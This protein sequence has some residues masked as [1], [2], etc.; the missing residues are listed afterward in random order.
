[1]PP[2]AS[3]SPES[4]VS[5]AEGPTLY[6]PNLSDEEPLF[7]ASIVEPGSP[8]RHPYRLQRQSRTSGMSSPC[9]LI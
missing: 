4:S 6:N 8:L 9:S 2:I 7:S 5:V 1:L 3:A